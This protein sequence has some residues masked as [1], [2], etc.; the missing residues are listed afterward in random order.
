MPNQ[1]KLAPD[2]RS[3][4]E[5]GRRR[6]DRAWTKKRRE[7]CGDCLKVG[8]K[9]R[10][11]SDAWC[12]GFC[13][14]HARARGYATLGAKKKKTGSKKEE[15]ANA[16]KASASRPP[17]PSK[18][19]HKQI[20]RKRPVS[21]SYTQAEQEFLQRFF[22]KVSPVQAGSVM[23][24]CKVP[25]VAQSANRIS[26][27]RPES[28]GLSCKGEQ[29]EQCRGWLRHARVYPGP[30]RSPPGPVRARCREEVKGSLRARRKLWRVSSMGGDEEEA[31]RIAFCEAL[32][33][34]S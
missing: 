10:R 20:P 17:Q 13:K 25:T 30:T 24:K 33:D 15:K 12:H 28:Q 8:G 31:D 2:R 1:W 34:D 18:G 21:A 19:R 5:R 16:G 26:S 11:Q 23:Q 9:S 14:R 3:D 6:C 29:D 7:V 4:A 32:A 27:C 22:P